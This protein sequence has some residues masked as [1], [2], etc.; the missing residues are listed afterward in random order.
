MKYLATLLLAACS[1]VPSA[2]F[3]SEFYNCKG[4]GK[5]VLQDGQETMSEASVLIYREAGQKKL[6]AEFPNPGESKLAGTIEND[7]QVQIVNVDKPSTVVFAGS[8]KL[9]S[10]SLPGYKAGLVLNGKGYDGCALEA[11]LLCE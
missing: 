2:A 10:T 1:V 5:N 9:T 7:G 11:L 6:I 3:S 4:V 8:V